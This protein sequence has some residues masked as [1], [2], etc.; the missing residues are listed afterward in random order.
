[1]QIIEGGTIHHV[2]IVVHDVERSAAALAESGIGPWHVW[3]ITPGS[4]T[5]RGED[6]PFS[7]R[8]AFAQ[9]GDANFELIAPDEGESIYVDFLQEHGEGM[10]HTC[11]AYATRDAL[12]VAKAELAR[13]G[14]TMTQSADMG[15]LGEFCYFE[16]PE[17]GSLVELLYVTELPAPE[18]TIE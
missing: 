13:Q 6:V 17:L 4:T 10:H 3:S 15:E 12:N 7:F 11:I 2:G 8:I 18:K 9:V 14:R 16:M 5:V 1:V